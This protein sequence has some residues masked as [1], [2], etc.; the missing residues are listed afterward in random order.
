[1]TEQQLGITQKIPGALIQRPIIFK[2]G[3]FEGLD[4]D[5]MGRAGP[6][7]FLCDA[8][9]P[10]EIV[11]EI[12]RVWNV[13]R[14]DFAKYDAMLGFMPRTPYPVGAEADEVH[15]AVVSAMQEMGLPIPKMK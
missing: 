8:S 11:K 10:E 14:A 3:A 4:Q 9:L 12:V 6:N 1:M 7:G 5:I 15:P 13:H 2:K